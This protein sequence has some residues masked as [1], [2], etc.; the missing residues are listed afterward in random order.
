[1]EGDTASAAGVVAWAGCARVDPAAAEDASVIARAL[2][3]A[4]DAASEALCFTCSAPE[5]VEFETDVAIAIA[6]V[7]CAGLLPG[8]IG[9]TANERHHY[10]RRSGSST[11]EARS[12]SSEAVERLLCRI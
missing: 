12:S 10:E 6:A 11:R 1:M 9:P 5:A 3:V 7:V 8:S 2:V 4:A